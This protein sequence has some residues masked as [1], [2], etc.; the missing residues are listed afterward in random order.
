MFYSNGSLSCEWT[1]FHVAMFQAMLNHQRVR[2]LELFLGDMRFSNLRSAF[3]RASSRWYWLFIPR[4]PST[5][6]SLKIQQPQH[7][8]P[9]NHSAALNHQLAP[10]NYWLA[11]GWLR[12]SNPVSTRI[13]ACGSREERCKRR[14]S[15]MMMVIHIIDI[16]YIYRYW[17]DTCLLIF[18]LAFSV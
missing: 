12:P 8:Q 9:L 13:L 6:R 2:F 18:C 17:Y 5:F 15:E 14:K 1:I 11:I 4:N 3:V 10:T 7:L 16:I